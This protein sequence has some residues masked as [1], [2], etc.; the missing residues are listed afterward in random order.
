MYVADTHTIAG[1]STIDIMIARDDVNLSKDIHMRLPVQQA[2][3]IP[4]HILP[5]AP[6]ERRGFPDRSVKGDLNESQCLAGGG[7]FTAET[8]WMIHA[9]IWKD[10]PTGMFSP[11]NPSAQ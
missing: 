7:H 11:T 10:S 2:K 6:R 4:R 1:C 9:W 5:S 8:Q 3:R